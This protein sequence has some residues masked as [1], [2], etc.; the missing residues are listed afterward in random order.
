MLMEVNYD[1]VYVLMVKF[2]GSL[3]L[4]CDV[5]TDNIGMSCSQ[6]YV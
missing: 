1:F 5:R 2:I 6:D 4:E 3:V